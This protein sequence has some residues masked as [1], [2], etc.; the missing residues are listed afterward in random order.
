[1]RVGFLFAAAG[2][3]LGG[4]SPFVYH[5][6]EATAELRHAM[7]AANE[8]RV[9]GPARVKL[10]ARTD[11]FV[12]PGL[13]FIPPREAERLLRATGERPTK[14]MLGLLIHATP[15]LAE[16]AILYSKNRPQAALP[17]IEFSGWQAAPGL[18][19]LRHK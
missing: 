14:E 3:F 11:L 16:R 1:V 15:E 2:L 19:A 7:E 6:P 4:C 8:A 9:D 5:S 18:W 10:A 17:E 13:V 12:Q